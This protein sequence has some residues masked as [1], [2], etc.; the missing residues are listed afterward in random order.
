[1]K[2]SERPRDSRGHFVSMRCPMSA[3]DGHLQAEEDRVL[4]TVWRC[5]GL[6]D[7]ENPA[8]ELQPCPYVHDPARGVQ[9]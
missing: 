9:P 7:P 1:M 6:I 4:G 3:C 5:D 8:V 2:I